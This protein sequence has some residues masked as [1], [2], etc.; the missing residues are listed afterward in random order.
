MLWST[1]RY[2][3]AEEAWIDLAERRIEGWPFS[4]WNSASAAMHQGRLGRFNQ[5]VGEAIE[6]AP[7]GLRPM[8]QF[9]TLA[10]QAQVAGQFGLER[11]ELAAL[12]ASIGSPTFQ[13]IPPAFRGYAGLV[14][15]FARAGRVSLA[16]A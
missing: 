15:T 8:I 2:A 9:A 7:P 10:G 13:E 1:G 12:Q 6:S 16:R 11:D 14:T 4:R 3:A 5:R